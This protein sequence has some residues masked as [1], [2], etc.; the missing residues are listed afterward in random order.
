[1]L[2]SIRNFCS[3]NKDFF[4]FIPLS[5]LPEPIQ[6][7]S[8]PTMLNHLEMHKKLKEDGRPNYCGLQLP[9]PSKLN[10]EKFFHYLKDYWDWQV[11]FFVKFGFPLDICNSKILLSDPGNHPSA[12]KFPDHIDYYLKEELKHN[13]ILGPFKHPPFKLHTSPF[14]TRE[15]SDSDNRRLIEDLSWPHRCSVNDAVQSDT[16]VGV[17]FY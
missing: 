5:A 6:H 4:G 1:M 7:K 3:Q 16:Y 11:A 14:L 13:A 9:V 10:A 8:T 12:E 15:R 17:D 2:F